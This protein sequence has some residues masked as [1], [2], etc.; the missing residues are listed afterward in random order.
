VLS[1]FSRSALVHDAELGLLDADAAD[2]H[3]DVGSY[4]PAGDARTGYCLYIAHHPT[5]L[6]VTSGDLACRIRKLA[7]EACIDG[8]ID[9]PDHCP[10]R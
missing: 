10:P 4:G 7:H 8:E 9:T 1:R 6:R 2:A 5:H 3:G